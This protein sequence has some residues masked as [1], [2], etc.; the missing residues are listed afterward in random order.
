MQQSQSFNTSYIGHTKWTCA[1]NGE[2]GL[3]VCIRFMMG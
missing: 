3:H 2:Q 1:N